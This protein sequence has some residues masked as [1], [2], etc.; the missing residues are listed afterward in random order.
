MIDIKNQIVQLLEQQEKLVVVNEDADKIVL[1]GSI[2]IN[3]SYNE[4]HLIGDFETKIIIFKDFPNRIPI[5]YTLDN[6]I[7]V[8]FQHVNR[9]KSLCLEVNIEI[10]MFI[11]ENKSLIEWF[12]KYVVNYYY[13]VMFFERYKR[14]PF[15]E[16]SHGKEG[17]KE[18]YRKQLNVKQINSIVSMLKFIKDGKI[19]GHYNCPCGS[20]NRIRN[21]HYEE[22]NKILIIRDSKEL[23]K[24]INELQGENRKII[25]GYSNKKILEILN[26]SF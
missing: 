4:I 16:R 21:C 2:N 3:A 23:E 8:E 26:L 11:I 22:L 13:S 9:D 1:E 10:K 6:K 12:K 24:D 20:G 19:R 7:P 18:F 17:I 5:I 14:Y 15:G 25:L